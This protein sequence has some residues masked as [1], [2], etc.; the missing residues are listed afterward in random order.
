VDTTVDEWDRVIAVN[1]KSVFL[2]CKYAIPVM[3]KQSG[4]KII[5]VASGWGLAGGAKAVAYCASKG[6]V[7]LL[8]K[9]LAVDHGPEGIAVNCVCPGDTE[10]GLLTDEARQLGLSD[11]ALIE[12]GRKR[13]L[14][15]VGKPEEIAASILYLASSAASFVTGAVL[16]VDGGGLAGSM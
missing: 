13:P 11:N 2:M 4:G 14:G 12:E 1:L 3:R 10:T 15:R 7:V 9:A 5:N 6:G 16:V 8:T